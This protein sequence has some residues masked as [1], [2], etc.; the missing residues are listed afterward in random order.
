MT[1]RVA[2]GVLSLLGDCQWLHLS[3][4]PIDLSLL[5]FYSAVLNNV[6]NV[7]LVFGTRAAPTASRYHCLRPRGFAVVK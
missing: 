4:H 2:H 5:P 6:K 3:M 7:P 1:I